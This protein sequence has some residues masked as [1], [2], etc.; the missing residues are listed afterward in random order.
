VDPDIFDEIQRL[1]REGRKA[2]LATIVQIRGSVPSFNTAKMLVR[3]D[4]STLGSVG[5]GCVEADVWAAAQDVM[6][7][8]KSRVMTFDLTEE[9]MAEGGLICGGKVEIFVEPIIPV[10]EMI[11]FGGGHISRQVSKIATIAGFRTTIV[12]NRPIY[13]NAE[14]FPEAEAIHSE[15]FEKAF[16]EIVPDENTYVIIVTRGHQEDQNVLRWAVQTNA[17]YIGMIGS[18]RKIR[19]ITEQLTSEGIPR[20][21]LERVYM[22]IGL[23]IG[24]VSP[25]EIAVAIVAEVIH[26]RRAGFKHPLSKKLY[27]TSQA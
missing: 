21:R 15:S 17:R 22:P 24:A 8:E 25:E 7:D 2:V 1:R 10:P 13:A 9:S 11:I 3:D 26:N 14:R 19:S 18:K 6:N 12:D 20:E 23:D 5:G 16:E 4:G 27:Q